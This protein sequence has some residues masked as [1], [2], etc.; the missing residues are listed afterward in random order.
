MHRFKIFYIRS[1]GENGQIYQNT[2]KNVTGNVWSRSGDG[3]SQVVYN[4][5]NFIQLTHFDSSLGFDP[6][7]PDEARKNSVLFQNTMDTLITLADFERATLRESGVANVR[8]TDLTNDPGIQKLSYIGDINQ[9]GVIDDLD[10]QK[11]ANYIVSPV[12][13]PLDNYE[14]QLANISQDGDGIS[15]YDLQ[16]LYNFLN[17]VMITLGNINMRGELPWTVGNIAMKR[18]EFGGREIIDQDSINHKQI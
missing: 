13:H 3:N 16:L 6:E 1:D 12:K 17:P 7:T 11:L 8:A 5:A 15:S 9:D 4:V 10:Y 18:E 14:M 2:L